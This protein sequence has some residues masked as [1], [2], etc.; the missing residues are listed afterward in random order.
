ML[1]T[2]ALAGSWFCL[3]LLC[4]LLSFLLS[5]HCRLASCPTT[6]FPSPAPAIAF[7]ASLCSCLM[8]YLLHPCLPHSCLNHLSPMVIPAHPAQELTPPR[9]WLPST[10]AGAVHTP[11]AA[12]TS[13][14]IPNL[15]VV[16]PAFPLC[17]LSPTLPPYSFPFSFLLFCL[18]CSFLVGHCPFHYQQ[19]VLRYYIVLVCLNS[20]LKLSVLKDPTA[21]PQSGI[22]N[23]F[24]QFQF[25]KDS[26]D[27]EKGL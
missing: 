21:V 17:L 11:P 4:H 8:P 1:F 6:S 16:M 26:G 19:M 9:V 13:T 3:P 27:I 14:A 18:S 2:F 22:R 12:W 15:L 24:S 10:V 20:I 25:K 23:Y 5:G 7:P